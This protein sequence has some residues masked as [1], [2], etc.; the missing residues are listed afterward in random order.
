[1]TSGALAALIAIPITLLAP[2]DGWARE[3]LTI[4]TRKVEENLQ[5]VPI[6]VS[7]IV[8]TEIEQKG[9]SNMRGVAKYTPGIEFDEGYGAQDRRIVIRGL[10]PTR[11]RSNAAF[12]VDGIDFTGEAMSTAGGAFLINQ[13]LIDVERIEVIRGPQ[14][15]LY[16]RSAFAGAIQ[17]VTKNPNLENWDGEVAT[18]LGSD[19]QYQLTG[20]VGG[21]ITSNFGLRLNALVYD[22]AGFY[23]NVLTG[24]EVGGAEGTGVALAGLWNATDDLSF[25]ARLAFSNDE[26]QPPSQAR[27][28]SN[29]IVNLPPELI[30]T[31]GAGGPGFPRA[32]YPDCAPWPPP[33]R[34]GTVTSCFGTPKPLST[35]TAPAGDTMAVTHSPN[36]NG[37]EYPGTDVDMTT[38]TL[39]ADWATDIGTFTSYT[40]YANT[41]SEQLFDGTWDSMPAG[42]YTSLDGSWTVTRLPCGPTGLE[43]CSPIGQEVNFENETD[44]FSQELRY[45]TNLDGPVNFT[46]GGLYWK[47]DVEQTED[48]VTVSPAYFR[49][50]PPGPPRDILFPTAASVLLDGAGNGIDTLSRFKSR[51]TEHWSIY[52]LIDWDITD[53]LTLTLEAR[54]VDE[55]ITNV[56]PECLPAETEIRTAAEG[57]DTDDDGIIDACNSAFRGGSSITQVVCEPPEC[58]PSLP[59]RLPNGYYTNAV[60]GDLEAKSDD[61]FVTPKATLEWRPTDTQM[62]YASIA[63]AEKPGGISSIAGGTFFEPDNSRFDSEKLLAYEIG[64]KT[65]WADGRVI[66]NGALFFQDYTDKQVGVTQ[67]DSRIQSDVSSIENAGE[68]EIWGIE[69][70]VAWEINEHF[71]V[72]G[73]YTWLDAEYTKFDSTTASGNEIARTQFAGNGGCLEII[74]SSD[75]PDGESESCRV[76]RTGNSIEDIPENAFVGYARWNTPIGDLNW[77]I[78]TNAIYN[79]ERWIEENNIKTLDSYWLFDF[80]VGLT[81]DTW[82]VVL[83]VDNAF[84]DD[85]IKS[86]TDTGSQIGTFKQGLFPP[87]PVDGFVISMPDPRVVG[88]RAKFAFGN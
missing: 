61:S 45:A 46:V 19:E 57:T 20:A 31:S 7:A 62:W 32:N 44:L 71:Y 53:A 69:L 83:F 51:D 77:F 36:P 2:A 39:V 85:T 65:A 59:D 30:Y 84:D 28:D 15:A 3:E 5:D 17:Y 14:S 50:F 24:T 47:E 25:K 13:R 49:G 55:E 81:S 60:T 56:G 16:G 75:M 38:F 8:A 52:G 11:G 70:D 4:T 42:S 35:G 23:D 80:R 73:A 67:F 86:G 10:S 82:E 18:D 64:G 12:L 33:P 68:A 72:S 74:P 88:I 41:D 29:T 78:D 6:S 66:V 34:D 48:S 37:G 26:Y 87:G 22:E 76:S 43:N 40:G 58:D 9:I 27:V 63:Q 1:M 21:P 79:D 54:Y